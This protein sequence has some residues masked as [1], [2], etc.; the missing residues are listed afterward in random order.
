MSLLEV[1]NLVVKYGKGF[2]VGPASFEMDPGILH[3]KGPNGG[4]KTTL[5]KAMSG[6]LVPAEGHVSVSGKDVHRD[7]AA[8]RHISF[9]SATPELPDFL[10]VT[11]A[12]QFVA[13]LRRTPDWDGRS[14][15]EKL[16][17]DPALTLSNASAGQRQKAEFICGLAGD[18]EVLLLDE[19]FAH[20]DQAGVRQLCEW[21]L[22]WAASRVIIFAHHGEPLVS[23]DA[24]LHIERH[25]VVFEPHA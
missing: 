5:M 15:C 24:T 18:P 10:S 19:T 21:I 1:R 12:Y 17:L 3:I 20:L 8:R 11:E 6:G 23:P 13:S 4:G 22:E 2:L 7:V 16:N 14:L 25:S 9:V